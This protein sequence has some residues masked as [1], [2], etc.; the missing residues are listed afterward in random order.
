MSQKLHKFIVKKDILSKVGQRYSCWYLGKQ[1]VR[2]SAYPFN[3]AARALL[4]L[5]LRGR[6]EMWD[7]D[8]NYHLMHGTIE[9]CALW[10]VGESPTKG[11]TEVPWKN[12]FGNINA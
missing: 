2:S 4:A 9:K 8:H 10:R 12:A 3:E 11:F 1:I 6:F 5:G 7:E